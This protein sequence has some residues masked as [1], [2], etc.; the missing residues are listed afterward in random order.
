VDGTPVAADLGSM[1]HLLIAG[2]TGSGKSVCV[3]AIIAS[4]LLKN[5]PNI[6]KFIM[7]DPKR[8]ELTGYNGIPHLVAP[9]VTELERIVSVLKWVTREMDERYRRFSTAGARNIEDYNKHVP[10]GTDPLPYIVVIIDELADLMMLAP[11]ETERVITRI[12][13]LA[14]ATGI[15]LVIATQRP[16]VDVVTGLIKANFPARIA[17]AVA[18]GT[19]SR[20][21]L[22]QPGADRLL[23]RGDMLYM[24]GDSPA[25][26]RLQG[27]YVSDNELGNMTRFWRGQMTQEEL[28][29]ASKPLIS[30]MVEEE[31]KSPIP[32]KSEG[33]RTQQN[34]FAPSEPEDNYEDDDEDVAVDDAL[35]NQAVDLVRRQNR[36]SVSLLQRKLRIGYTRAARLIDLMEERGVVGPATEGSKPREVL[37]PPK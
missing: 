6:V 3:N 13:A 25:P 30:A 5:T 16:S 18:S 37:L 26:V 22:D 1:P 9:V 36:A 17:F 31:G 20:V 19:D 35:Y 34:M 2:T 15:H 28:I 23:G 14:R 7:V 10:T 11:D 12:A 29:A 27:V 32:L 21:I 4:L 8:V 33:K 24:S